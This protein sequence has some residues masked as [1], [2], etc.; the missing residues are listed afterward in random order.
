MGSRQT[1][2]GT[3]RVRDL[4]EKSGPSGL[5]PAADQSPGGLEAD[6][7]A[8]APA[9]PGKPDRFLRP[10]TGRAAGARGPRR[11][12]RSLA[13]GATFRPVLRRHTG[14]KKASVTAGKMRAASAV[15]ATVPAGRGRRLNRDKRPH[16]HGSPGS[17]ADG[18]AGPR[19]AARTTAASAPGGTR[20]HTGPL[21]GES[22]GC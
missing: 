16:G 11:R 20:T 2:P 13:P 21:A 12:R 19:A 5:P 7:T 14:S 15:A 4:D 3:L 17:S 1:F 6:V 9:N 8:A 10:A 18:L 22:G